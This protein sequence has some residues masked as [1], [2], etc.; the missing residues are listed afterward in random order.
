MGTVHDFFRINSFYFV[1][2]FLKYLFMYLTVLGL[3]CSVQD[4]LVVARGIQFPHQG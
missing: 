3:S 2:F 4:P 1:L